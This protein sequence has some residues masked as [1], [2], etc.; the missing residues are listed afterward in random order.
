MNDEYLTE[1]KQ[2]QEFVNARTAVNFRSVN[3]IES[4]EWIARTLKRFNYFKLS[5]K[6]KG[7]VRAYI[8]KITKYSLAQLNRL[9]EQYRKN[10]WIGKKRKKR[11]C[12]TKIYNQE[13][14]LLLA[15]TDECHQTLSGPATKNPYTLTF[16]KT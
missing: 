4:Y 8:K 3:P 10:H 6:D 1:L 13:D 7:I 2:V 16:S 12:F 9:F 14:I 5:K 11:N 15:E